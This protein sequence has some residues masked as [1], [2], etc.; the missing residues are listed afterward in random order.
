MQTISEKRISSEINALYMYYMY[1]ITYIFYNKS[2]TY[3]R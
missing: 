3:L 2:K 1:H